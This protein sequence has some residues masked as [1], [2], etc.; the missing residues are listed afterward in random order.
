MNHKEFRDLITK[1]SRNECSAA[2]LEDLLAGYR[3]LYSR[4]ADSQVALEEY[5]QPKYVEQMAG[6][7]DTDLYSEEG[8]E[9]LRDTMA[10]EL[11]NEVSLL[12]VAEILLAQEGP[13]STMIDSLLYS[14]KETLIEKTLDEAF[15]DSLDGI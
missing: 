5:R 12:A 2:E 1:A 10:D 3:S 6:E 13:V 9:W 7:T 14:S 15:K 11:R 4:F 8:I